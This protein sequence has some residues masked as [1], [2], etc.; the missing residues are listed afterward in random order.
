MFNLNCLI[1]EKLMTMA[2]RLVVGRDSKHA[3]FFLAVVRA[4]YFYI[5][6]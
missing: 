4:I 6:N 2:K 3:F 5:Q 1:L